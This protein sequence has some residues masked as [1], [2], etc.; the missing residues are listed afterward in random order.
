MGR[1]TC[2]LIHKFVS[3]TLHVYEINLDLKLSLVLDMITK[4]T[5]VY[6]CMKVYY[7]H[8]IPPT[9]FGHSCGIFKEVRYKG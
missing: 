9:C 8:R 7:T 2:E 3:L 1:T 5:I 4:H 6:K